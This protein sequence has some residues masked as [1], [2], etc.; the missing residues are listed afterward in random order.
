[1]AIFDNFIEEEEPGSLQD[2]IKMNFTN[3]VPFLVR[4]LCGNTLIVNE[5][6]LSKSNLSTIRSNRLPGY[7]L[8]TNNVSISDAS[9]GSFIRLG[10]YLKEKY[11]SWNCSDSGLLL[12]AFINFM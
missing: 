2:N 3:T 7:T 4:S 9:N 6:L 12:T 11:E 8:D 1:M 5:Y 10:S